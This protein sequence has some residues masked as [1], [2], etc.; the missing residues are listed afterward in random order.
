MR[1]TVMA[2]IK[3]KRLRKNA[4]KVR[5][6]NKL[7]VS[8]SET[9]GFET[10]SK[11]IAPEEASTNVFTESKGTKV[12]SEKLS[13]TIEIR[14]RKAKRKDI[15]KRSGYDPKSMFKSSPKETEVSPARMFLEKRKPDVSMFASSARTAVN[16]GLKAADDSIDARHDTNVSRDSISFTT[17]SVEEGSYVVRAAARRKRLRAR[18]ERAKALPGF[19]KGKAKGSASAKEKAQFTSKPDFQTQEVAR[20]NQEQRRHRMKMA[21]RRKYFE[22]LRRRRKQAQRTVKVVENTAQAVGK[23]GIFVVRHPI[24]TIVII[25]IALLVLLIIS[26]ASAGMMAGG[27]AV[28]TLVGG[29]YQSVPAEIDKA[30]N[31]FSEKELE[32]QNRID[33]IESDYPGYDEY[34]Y[35][36]A[37][38]EH[39]PYALISYL[40]AKY[41]DF[42]ADVIEAEIQSLFDQMY[43]LTISEREV[44]RPVTDPD[45][46]RESEET[47]RV[48]DVTLTAKDLNTIAINSLTPEQISIYNIYSVTDGAV[49][50]YYKPLDLNWRAYIKSYYGYRKNPST[51]ANEF[52]RGIDIA[53]PE[54]TE[55]LAAQ[56]GVVTFSG[57][58]SE[59]G[60]YIVIQNEAGYESKYAH[61]SSINVSVGQEVTHG[62]V[63][64]KTGSTGSSTG[65]HLHLECLFNG[66]YYNPL[67]YFQ[68]GEGGIYGDLGNIGGFGPGGE[69]LMEYDDAKVQALMDEAAKYLGY[70]YVWGGSSPSTSFDCSGYV[71]WCLRESGFYNVD[72]LTAQGL[73]NKCVR[74]SASDV[75]PGDLVFFQGT[76]R[77]S[78]TVT[79]VG[80]YCGN[81]TMIHCGDPIK[82]ASIN[83]PYWQSHFYAF[84]R[85]Q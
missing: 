13:G 25:L 69:P 61:L 46:G 72:R 21:Q 42:N 3:K 57:Y 24:I 73:Y 10:R 66:E 84:G 81:G 55:V 7:N 8:S 59:Y 30:E 5:K 6:A 12:E 2:D 70:P 18:G 4:A 75:K 83:T 33:R 34:N 35:N 63:I 20:K 60:N 22:R 58:T 48:L 26:A 67:F 56:D 76:Y 1:Q 23:T 45:T 54:G 27:G 14:S 74:V 11:F 40:S 37:P 51:G 32:L 29:S 49:Q 36:I 47:V 65:S 79:H 19:A 80:I 78:S 71:S 52:H 17:K 44:T 62:D 28:S 64:G 41:V 43:E 50:R 85:L 53:V 68:N 31:S 16:R 77:T 9:K 39:D 15:L 82:Y 38:I